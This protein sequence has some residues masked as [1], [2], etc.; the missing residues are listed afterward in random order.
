MYI[1]VQKIDKGILKEKQA[2]FHGIRHVKLIANDYLVTVQEN[3]T[4]KEDFCIFSKWCK[5]SQY[6][7]LMQNS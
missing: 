5:V 6:V 4:E 7:F 3:K 2:N 1:N